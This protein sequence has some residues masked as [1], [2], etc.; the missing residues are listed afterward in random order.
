MRLF[1]ALLLL[2]GCLWTCQQAA[3]ADEPAAAAPAPVSFTKD[4]APIL[5]QKC[6]ACHGPGDPKG[7]YQITSFEL[8]SKPGASSSA[9]VTAGKPDESELLRLI[10]SEDTGERMPKDGDPLSAEQVATVRRWIEE[11]AKFDSPDPK[12]LLASIV[13]RQPHPAPPESYRVA[14]PVT[15][16]AFRPDGQELA[17]SGYREITIWNPT[18]GALLRRIKNVPQRT[19]GLAYSP[20]GNL[21]AAAGGMPGQSGEVTLYNPADGAIVRQLGSMS[22]VAWGVAFNPAGNKLAACGADRSIRLYDV[23]TGKEER[24]IEDHADWV[25]AVAWNHDGT[26]LASAS[27][28]KTAKLFDAAT[29]ESLLTYPGHG[30]QVFGVAFNADSSQVFSTGRDKKIHVWKTADAAK[31][32]EI[33]GFGQEVYDITI[34]GGQVYCCSADKTARQFEA[35]ERKHVRNYEGHADWVYSLS[36]NDATKRLATGSFDGEVR[37]WNAADGALI[38]SFKAAPGLTPAQPAVQQAAAK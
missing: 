27:R 12:A 33:A 26:R 37:V 22:D 36:Y 23:A 21:L 34:Q 20:D 6:Q 28:D 19:L 29:G 1:S 8:L 31:V 30:E 9:P 14:V 3:R 18:S 13:P 24:V 16:L 15:A 2:S 32:G 17:A 38:A 25:M 11:G 4:V 10:A 7:D 5:V 35:G